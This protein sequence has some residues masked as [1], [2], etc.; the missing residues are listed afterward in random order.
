MVR[1]DVI[2]MEKISI[3]IKTFERKKALERL[4]DSIEKYYP[5]IPIIIVDDSKNN[6]SKYILKK[7]KRL[8]IKYI[9]EDFDIGLSKGRNILINN[10]LCINIYS[11]R[12]KNNRSFKIISSDCSLYSFF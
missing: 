2:K 7:F 1:K 12:N 5:N 4:L 8:N 11:F 10:V 6:Y 9:V 3:V